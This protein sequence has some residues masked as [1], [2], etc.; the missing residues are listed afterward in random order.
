MDNSDGSSDELD[1][2]V[3]DLLGPEWVKED[4]PEQLAELVRCHGDP[5]RFYDRLDEFLDDRS[6]K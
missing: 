5:H 2:L 4:P 3:E 6:G 1:E